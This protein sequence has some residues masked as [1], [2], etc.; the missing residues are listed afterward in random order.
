MKFTKNAAAVL[1]R[2]K[3]GIRF[4]WR[5]RGALNRHLDNFQHDLAKKLAPDER[6]TGGPFARMHYPLVNIQSSMT[7]PKL[8]GSYEE[9]LHPE[10]EAV[11]GSDYSNVIDIGCGEG[12]YAVGLATRIPGC[13]VHAFD[14]DPVAL[15]ATRNLARLNAVSDRID[16]TEGCA[17]DQLRHLS[18][19]PRV[20]ILS[21]C[22]G[23]E[24]ELIDTECLPNAPLIDILIECHDSPPD[25]KIADEIRRR[26]SPTHESRLITSRAR[27][28]ERYPRLR[29]WSSGEL[30]MAL[31]ESR[32]AGMSWLILR[33]RDRGSVV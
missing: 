8:L 9:E 1:F 6:V 3:T 17:R 12:Y 16:I 19:G 24:L 26:F 32:P 31:S 11:V 10:I 22:E 33:Q 7:L 2:S 5:V 20:F 27:Q 28:S 4:A 30:E 18:V 25:T 13:R 15:M 23:A 29:G 21:D 14:L